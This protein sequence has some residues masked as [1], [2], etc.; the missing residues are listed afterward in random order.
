MEL[1]DLAEN[2]RLPIEIRR[3]VDNAVRICGW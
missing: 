3:I 1:S 2:L